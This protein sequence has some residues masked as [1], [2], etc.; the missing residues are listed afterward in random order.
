MLRKNSF[1]IAGEGYAGHFAPQLANLILQTKK[2]LINLKGIAIANSLLD[3][4]TNYNS[5]ADFYWSHGLISEQTF[6]LLTKVCNFSQIKREQI[7]GGVH[8]I[9][10]EVYFQL[11]Q[12]VGDFRGYTSVLDNICSPWTFNSGIPGCVNDPTFTYLNR[13]D[14]QNALRARV[15]GKKSWSSCT[16]LNDYDPHDYEISMISK[17]GTLVKAGLRVL[18][19]R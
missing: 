13:K 4:N 15:F 7:N 14:V 9:C 10:K 3:F 16:F 1:F 18:G 17:L 2:N 6:D 5:V 19:Y 8:G 12:E 11:V